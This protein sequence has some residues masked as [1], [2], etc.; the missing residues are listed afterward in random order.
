MKTMN[1][2]EEAVKAK[3]ENPYIIPLKTPVKFEG[4]QYDCIDL[5]GLEDLRATD[6]IAINRR[7]SVMGTGEAFAENSLEYTLHLA[8]AAT[9]LPIEF[10]EQL[11]INTAM[12]VKSRVL[13]FLF[14]QD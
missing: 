13:L 4:K 11:K 1:E 14:R 5:T 3:G 6:L 8:A 12:R 2:L 10:F 7:L 9:A